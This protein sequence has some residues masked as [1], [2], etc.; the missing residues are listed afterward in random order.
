MH[1]FWYTYVLGIFLRNSLEKIPWW[2]QNQIK[3]K[4]FILVQITETDIFEHTKNVWSR[5][6]VG[7]VKIP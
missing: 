4:L 6:E 1:F 2:H 3:N 5:S 7:R